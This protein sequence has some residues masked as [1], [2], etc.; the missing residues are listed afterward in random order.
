MATGKYQR[1]LEPDG[2]VLLRAWARDGLT[3]DQIARNCGVSRSTLSAW[4][5]AHPDISD[6]LKKG[7]DIADIEV[8]NALYRRAVGYAYD[9]TSVEESPD[10]VKRKTV[11]K[12]MAPDVTAQIF[13]LKNRR[14]DV[15]R[16]RQAASEAALEKALEGARE[17]LGGIA[18]VIK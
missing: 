15:W 16:E 8:E 17:I 7:K 1:W 18:S 10:G 5:L 4:K 3:D 13:W 12:Q 6:A 14:P 9:E 2:L 11:T